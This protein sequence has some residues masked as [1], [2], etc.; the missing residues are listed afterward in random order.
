MPPRSSPDKEKRAR[1]PAGPVNDRILLSG[2]ALHLDGGEALGGGGSF[3]SAGPVPR[4][5]CPAR[6][7]PPTN[8][9]ER[10]RKSMSKDAGVMAGSV[11]DTARRS[12]IPLLL[13]RYL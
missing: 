13:C 6:V 4:P 8:Q 5:A 10:W 7:S 12:L 9:K 11:P 2:D 3:V 1:R